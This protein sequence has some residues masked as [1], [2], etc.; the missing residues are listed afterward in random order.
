MLPS[1]RVYCLANINAI[2]DIVLN[3]G[4]ALSPIDSGPINKL[5]SSGYARQ[6]RIETLND[7][8]EGSRDRLWKSNLSNCFPKQLSFGPLGDPDSLRPL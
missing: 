6:E 8:P 5:L 2:L 7:R 1:R 3:E 4:E